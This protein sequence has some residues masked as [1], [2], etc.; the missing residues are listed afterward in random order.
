MYVPVTKPNI[1]NC[2]QLIKDFNSRVEGG[3]ILSF[4]LLPAVILPKEDALGQ[5]EISYD[6]ENMEESMNLFRKKMKAAW[7]NNPMAKKFFGGNLLEMVE[8]GFMEM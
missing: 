7:A 3:F 5:E 4:W 1:K 2:R 6:P 8:R